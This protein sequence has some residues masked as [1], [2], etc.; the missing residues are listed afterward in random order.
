MAELLL[1]ILSEEIPA[2]MQ[3]KAADDLK[4]L[5]CDGLKDAGLEFESAVTFV[6]P[7]RLTLV[8]DGLPTETPDISEE[9]RGPKTDAPEKAVQGFLGSVGLT[10][11]EVEKRETDKGEFY[12]A[13]IEKKGQKTAE[14]LVGLI[15]SAMQAL[16]WP[17]SM[18][19]AD[20]AIRWVRPMQGIVCVFDTSIVAV[21]F[22]PI[23]ASNRTQ[24]HRFLTNAVIE[25]KD[26]ADYKNALETGH[27]LIDPLERRAAIKGDADA[28]AAKEGLKLIDDP[29]LLDEVAGLVEWPVTLLGSIDD[30]F[31]DVP[32]EVLTTTMRKNQKYFA[33]ETSDGNLAPKFIVVANKE[34]PD[35]GAAIVAGNERV[36]RARLADAKFFWDQDRKEKLDTRIPK[37]KD[38]TFHAKL[39]TLAEKMERVGKLAVDLA[40]IVGADKKQVARAAELA[41][42]DLTTGMVAEFADLQGLMGKYYAEHDD[43]APEVATAIAEHYSPQGP[44][45]ACPTAPVSVA[46]ALADKIDTLVGF[47]AIDEKPTGSKD[48]YALRRAA[49]S[50]IRLIIENEHRVLLSDIFESA[51]KAGKYKGDMAA[52]FDDLLSFFAD[53]LKVHL[54]EEGVRHDLIAAIL[55]LELEDDFVRLLSRVGALTTFISSEDGANLLTAYKRAANILRIEEKKDKTSY[56]AAADAGALDQAE[57]KQ[58]HKVLTSVIG[59]ISQNLEAEDYAKAMSKL[60]SLRAPVDAFFDKVTVNC[61]DKELRV[62][63]LRLLSQIRTTM[64]QVADFSKIEGGER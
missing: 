38:I 42:A 41:K 30:E 18:R 36:L 29:A 1:E 10:L 60:A 49:L 46:V 62:N 53:R 8:V 7:R 51:W 50:I 14:L 34:T 11:D 54:K 21:S 33:L 52:V 64:N 31:M 5:V 25:V 48:P 3:A 27:V 4:R 59:E 28:L 17:K 6:T 32:P 47:W 61:D 22:G 45:D 63:R 56:A 39:G 15:E 44:S 40:E 55:S 23:E 13:V 37:L 26:F 12:F 20:H 16:P 35:G 57:E 19:W 43:E 24:A 2:R 9:R 58:L